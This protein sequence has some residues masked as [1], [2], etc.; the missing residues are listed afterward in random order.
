MQGA[1]KRNRAPHKMVS[2][3][4]V[5]GT[6][7]P[8]A[9]RRPAPHAEFLRAGLRAARRKANDAARETVTFY[10]T[11]SGSD[12]T[13]CP[14]L[15]MAIES[16]RRHH[17]HAQEKGRDD[18]GLL[19]LCTACFKRSGAASIRTGM[20]ATA[21]PGRPYF[22]RGTPRWPARWRLAVKR[23]GIAC[24]QTRCGAGSGWLRLA[25]PA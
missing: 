18:P 20:P 13:G 25:P 2:T 23:N 19:V 1:S 22:H 12:A 15:G 6:P 17:E 4:R 24:R 5:T 7:G 9:T 11:P 21:G 16:A 8:E 14:D 10:V 3:P